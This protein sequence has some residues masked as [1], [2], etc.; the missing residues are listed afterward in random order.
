M[1][2]VSKIYRKSTK[3]LHT[4]EVIQTTDVVFLELYMYI[5]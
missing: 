4:S 5:S 3:R 2:L 1:W